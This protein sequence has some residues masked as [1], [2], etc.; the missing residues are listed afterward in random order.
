MEFNEHLEKDFMAIPNRIH[1][2]INKY[3]RWGRVKRKDRLI[4]ERDIINYA[5]CLT[6]VFLDKMNGLIKN[7]NLENISDEFERL[8][9]ISQNNTNEQLQNLAIGVGTHHDTDDK[10]RSLIL[11]VTSL[12]IIEKKGKYV[13]PATALIFN[14]AYN[15]DLDFVMQYGYSEDEK[16][17]KL[18][19]E[20][21]KL[22]GCVNIMC[23]PDYFSNNK[24]KYGVEELN[25]LIKAKQMIKEFKR[26]L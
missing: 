1:R 7:N 26:S 18:L 12:Y 11:S 23:L 21:L 16:G 14:R 5:K 9:Y 3:S 4:F 25:E 24:F 17:E 19:A 8:I 6:D 13:G 15:M 2:K 10:I 20:Y 22:G